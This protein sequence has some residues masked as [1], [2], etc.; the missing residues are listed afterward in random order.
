MNEIL[1]KL[2][3]LPGI[4]LGFTIHEFA[5][6][7]TAFRLGDDT[8]KYQG[9]LTLSPFAHIDLM[10][11]LAIVLIGFGWAKPVQINPRKFKNPRRDDIL[12]SLAGPLANLG[13]AIISLIVYKFAAPYASGQL[14]NVLLLLLVYCIIYNGILF[15]FNLMPVPPLDGY[16]IFK[17]LAPVRFYPFFSKIEK[18]SSWI[19]LIF[20]FFI[21]NT[22]ILPISN[23]IFAI[24]I[25]ISK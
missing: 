7:I 24:I 1:A 19:L 2:Y 5:H 3:I 23:L 14:G 20:V 11:L 10:G 8:P 15:V 6:A 22:I 21:A 4:L 16:S 12:V 17:N 25:S 18:Y 9:R 13:L